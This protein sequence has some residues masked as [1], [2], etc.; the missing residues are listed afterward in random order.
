MTIDKIKTYM[1]VQLFEYWSSCTD[2]AAANNAKEL[3][4]KE[5]TT[6]LLCGVQY[7]AELQLLQNLTE[8]E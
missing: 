5:I 6:G 4:K 3:L 7:Y 1:T 8:S 2:V